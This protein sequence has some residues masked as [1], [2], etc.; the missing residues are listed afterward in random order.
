MSNGHTRTAPVV[1]RVTDLVLRTI[2]IAALV[3]A[4]AFFA[5]QQAVSPHHRA[6]KGLVIMGLMALMFRFDMVYSV[7]LFAILFAF[8]T[9][10]SIGSSNTVLM[11]IIPMI[12]AVRA[13]SARAPLLRRTPVDLAIGAFLMLHFVSLFN[14]TDP[15]LLAHSIVVIW[16][17]LSACALFYCIYM[18]VNDEER[19]FRFGKVV[20]VTCT[21]VMLTAVVELFFPGK[22][23]IPG[24]IG[25]SN[26]LGEGILH[27]RVQGL[28]VGGSFDSH[29]M[30]ADFGTQ[31]VLFMAYFGII[32]RNPM[33]KVFWMGSVAT[34]LIAILATAN[35]GATSG[36]VL[37]FI[38]ALWFFRKRLGAT[39]I[40]L[41]AVAASV[42]LVVADTVLSERTIAVSVL[43]RFSNTQFEGLVPENRV[44]T[45]GPT[46]QE[47]LNKPF[48]GHGPY[49]DTGLGLT[50]RMWPHNGYLFYFFTMGLFGLL[51]FLW[52]IVKVFRESQIWRRRDIRDTRLG[53]FLG[54][55]Q[56]WLLVL[57]LE[58]MR[59][60]HQRDDIYP[61]IV[62][63]CFGVIVSGAA[64]VRRKLAAQSAAAESPTASMRPVTSKKS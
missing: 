28:R 39:R 29:G 44:M 56:I 8:P 34:T 21:L 24:W 12:W 9:G 63:M 41:I 14:V 46:F 15:L 59:T 20:C 4:A 32:A 11:T 2:P 30:L 19:L 58:Q 5:A 7:Y 1:G 18:F 31:L 45:W 38:L 54:I 43:D 6:I 61:Y 42:G 36:L 51:A 23:I 49:F 26:K 22:Q 17:Q 60:D 16:R 33:E 48:F 13:T 35:R 53:T 55:A 37:G 25:L 62:W 40:A 64:I 57:L 27:H 3:A 10:I 47:A 50:K 52:V